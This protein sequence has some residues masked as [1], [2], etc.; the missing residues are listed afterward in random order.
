LK[1]VFIVFYRGKKS[2]FTQQIVG[3]KG[4]FYI[5]RKLSFDPA[6]GLVILFLF[7]NVRPILSI[8]DH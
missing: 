6:K 5:F 7:F 2:L 3:A 1:G 4:F 8:N